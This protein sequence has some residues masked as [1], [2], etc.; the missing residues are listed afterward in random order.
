MQEEEREIRRFEEL[1]EQCYAR[2][3]YTFTDF[4]GL[5]EYALFLSVAPRFSYVPY[6]VFGGAEGCERV[7]V[8]F[9]SA[10]VLSYPEE[11]FPIAC[12]LVAPSAPKFAEPFSHR[13]CLGA[14]MNLGI[15]RECLGDIFLSE[16]RAYLFCLEK[17]APYLC[18]NLEK[19]RHTPVRVTRTEPPAAVYSKVEE[20][21]VQVS[22]PRADAVVA[23]AYRLSRTEGADLFAARRV[24]VNGRLTENVSADLRAGDLVTVRG[25]GRFRV[26]EAR[27]L[28]RKGKLN[29]PIE[30]YV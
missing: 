18:E 22:S 27:G 21:T 23:H 20:E 15:K 28:S 17:I 19:V 14:V 1:A 5:S 4:L 11:E 25:F 30:K 6:T 10:E 29:L 24:F 13:D 9:G 3:R 8:R 2:G 26:G 7:M 16:G 12:L